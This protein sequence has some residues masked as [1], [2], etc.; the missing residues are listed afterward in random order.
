MNN[1]QAQQYQEQQILNATPAEQIVML[2]DGALKFLTKTR[3][4]IEE[5]NI[6]ERYNNNKRAGDI[7]AYLLETLDMEKGGSVAES[8]A[9]TYYYML[10]KLMAVD[11]DNSIEAID[12]VM[13]HLRVLRASWEKI[14]QGKGGA[15]EAAEEPPEVAPHPQ[16]AVVE[17]EA[18]VV[19]AEQQEQTLSRPV[20]PHMGAYGQAAKQ[21]PKKDEG[22]KPA[23]RRGATV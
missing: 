15:V 10:R 18:P 21:L 19:R 6:Q 7:I 22:E 3:E 13:G 20:H 17:D 5:G 8:L 12:D 11:M 2:Y 4:A 14:A 9:K 23:A 1:K 16:E